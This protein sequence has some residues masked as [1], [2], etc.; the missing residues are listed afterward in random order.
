MTVQQ[1]P[2]P[3]TPPPP[4]ESIFSKERSAAFPLPASGQSRGRAVLS[5]SPPDSGKEERGGRRLTLPRPPCSPAA[6]FASCPQQTEGRQKP[7]TRPFGLHAATL[8][9]AESETHWAQTEAHRKPSRARLTSEPWEPWGRGSARL[10]LTP[11]LK[12]AARR[13]QDAHRKHH[14]RQLHCAGPIRMS[15][16]RPLRGPCSVVS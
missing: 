16:K 12:R 5:P 14:G 7:A 9:Q 1:P 6:A 13:R 3:S 2:S 15:L 11:Q 4:P 10:A 8:V